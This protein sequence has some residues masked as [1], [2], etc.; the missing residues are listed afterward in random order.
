MFNNFL[1]ENRAVYEII[2]KNTIDPGKPQMT[3]WRM[4]IAFWIPKSTNT[5]LECVIFIAFSLQQWL[6]ELP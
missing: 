4:R 2:L 5:H 1:P 6:H 3:M